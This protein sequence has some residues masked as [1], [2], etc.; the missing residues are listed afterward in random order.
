MDIVSLFKVHYSI[1]NFMDKITWSSIY[2]FWKHSLHA[3]PTH[4]VV[5]LISLCIYAK[6]VFILEAIWQL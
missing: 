4:L 3:L 1:Q 6:D 5:I 2:L